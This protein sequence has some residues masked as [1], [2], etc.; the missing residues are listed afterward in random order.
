MVDFLYRKQMNFEQIA[1]GHRGSGQNIV[2]GYSFLV[3]FLKLFWLLK[4][5]IFLVLY[6]LDIYL[7]LYRKNNYQIDF[8]LYA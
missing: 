3:N 8:W 7:I 5:K 4:L 2:D 1:C 6:S